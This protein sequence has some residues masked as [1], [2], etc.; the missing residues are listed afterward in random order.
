L[1]LWGGFASTICWP[2]S[3][4]LVQH[5]GWRSAIAA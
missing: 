3:A 1:T 5:F 2:L 4:R